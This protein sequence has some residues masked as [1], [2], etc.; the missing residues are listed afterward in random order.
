M[1]RIR[2]IPPRVTSPAAKTGERDFAVPVVAGLTSIASRST[3]ASARAVALRCLGLVSGESGAALTCIALYRTSGRRSELAWACEDAAA[4]LFAA[5]CAADAIPLLDEAADIHLELRANADLTRTDALL[6]AHGV[7]RRRHGPS[8][9]THGWASLSPTELTVVDL[10]AQGLSNPR[11]GEPLFISRRTVETHIGHVV[12]KLAIS[13]RAQL[14]A[15]VVEHGRRQPPGA[16]ERK[17]PERRTGE[18]P[19]KKG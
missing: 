1:S 15:A 18:A 17:R 16:R 10:V 12:R 3:S 8:P 9:A 19:T 7:R 4:V 11:I 13:S 2:S 14:A 6:R 5:G